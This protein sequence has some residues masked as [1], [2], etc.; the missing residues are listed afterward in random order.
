M[1]NDDDKLLAAI[2]KVSAQTSKDFE[3]DKIGLKDNVTDLE[4]IDKKN[5]DKN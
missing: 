1:K 5:V 2:I 4:E 3:A